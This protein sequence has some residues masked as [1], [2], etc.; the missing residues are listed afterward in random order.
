MSDTQVNPVTAR[1]I[2]TLIE[3]RWIVP[4]EPEN[5]VFE[6]HSIAVDA[7][8]ILAIL[9]ADETKRRYSAK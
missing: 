7:G 6:H 8:R 2:D 5:V 1:Q 9:P 3:A 4:V